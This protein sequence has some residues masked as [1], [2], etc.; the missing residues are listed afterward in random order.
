MRLSPDSQGPVTENV[1]G[2]QF[3]S[4][5]AQGRVTFQSHP[6]GAPIFRGSVRHCLMWRYAPAASVPSTARR[7]ARKPR[8][9]ITRLVVGQR[10]PAWREDDLLRKVCQT[11]LGLQA[12]PYHITLSLYRYIVHILH[13]VLQATAQQAM[14]PRY[15]SL[16]CNSNLNCARTKIQ[17]K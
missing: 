15:S 5:T 17:K 13:F 3:R 4:L 10:P 2:A 9:S 14:L 12:R 6:A 11:S 7:P 1:R 16:R 8:G